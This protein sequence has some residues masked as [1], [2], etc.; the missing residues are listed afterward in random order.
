MTPLSNRPNPPS[1]AGPASLD[2]EDLA[3]DVAAGVA[4]EKEQGAVQL[5]QLAGTA[6]G[7]VAADPRHRALVGEHLGRHL[8]LE[9]ARSEGVDPY[10]APR[11]LGSQVTGQ[12]DHARLAR[13][14]A[15]EWN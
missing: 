12:A 8:G 10:A 7:C 1:G 13:R 9:P 11:P 3:G 5:V 4:G 2:S 6:H 14:I 15:G